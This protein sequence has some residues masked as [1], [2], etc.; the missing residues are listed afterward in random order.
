[1]SD[2]PPGKWNY[3]CN[4]IRCRWEQWW[5]E[6]DNFV[7]GMPSE[8]H[9]EGEYQAYFDRREHWAGGRHPNPADNR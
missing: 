5:H 2:H 1:M 8:P 7:I 4:C 6:G 3:A 9:P